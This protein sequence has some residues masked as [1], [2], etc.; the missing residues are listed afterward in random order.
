MHQ[1]GMYG[2]KLSERF[3]SSFV[4]WSSGLEEKTNPFI[5]C[6]KGKESEWHE[7]CWDRNEL[8]RLTV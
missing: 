5:K 3:K 7:Y 2:S 6:I 4:H 8:A 1:I